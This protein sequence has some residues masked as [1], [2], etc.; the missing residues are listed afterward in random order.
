MTKNKFEVTGVLACDVTPN[1]DHSYAHFTLI[2]NFGGRN[3]PLRLDCIYD[4]TPIPWEV[5]KKGSQLLIKASGM[6]RHDHIVWRVYEIK[7]L[8]R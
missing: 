1:P 2:H 6:M 5:L 3:P 8:L 7:E 4:K